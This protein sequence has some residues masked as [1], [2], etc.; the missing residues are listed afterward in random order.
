VS[1][2]QS[3]LDKN[4]SHDKAVE[5]LL[6]DVSS[7]DPRDE[8]TDDNISTSEV[9]SQAVES[10]TS[11]HDPL[12]LATR[13]N[14]MKPTRKK[15]LK[16]KRPN[17]IFAGFLNVHI[18][19]GWCGSTVEDLRRNKHFPLYPDGRRIT[20]DFFERQLDVNYGQRI[21]G[22][23]HPP[24]TGN[25]TFYLSSDDNSELWLSNSSDPTQIRKI[26]WVGNR[27]NHLRTSVADFTVSET[28]K[29]RNI[30][31]VKGQMYF[32]E[33]L[34]KQRAF[35]NHVLVA[36]KGPGVPSIKL[37][38]STYLSAYFDEDELSS[39]VNVL[40]EYIPE[41]RASYPTHHHGT[42]DV[43]NSELK[44]GGHDERDHFHLTPLVDD[45]DIDGLLPKCLYKPSYLVDFEVN[46]YEGVGLIHETAVYPDDNTELTHMI[47]LTSCETRITDSHGNFLNPD[48]LSLDDLFLN[49]NSF[50]VTKYNEIDE[51]VAKN[52]SN[53]SVPLP[54]GRGFGS[55]IAK[56][57]RKF[58]DFNSYIQSNARIFGGKQKSLVD[59]HSKNANMVFSR[60]KLTGINSEFGTKTF[61]PFQPKNR[62]K[63]ETAKEK[64]KAIKH[65]DVRKRLRSA[66]KRQRYKNA[67]RNLVEQKGERRVRRTIVDDQNKV[68]TE[69]LSEDSNNGVV[70]SRNK[71]QVLERKRDFIE[72]GQ[73]EYDFKE[74][75]FARK[76]RKL[77]ANYGGKHRSGIVNSRFSKNYKKRK[78]ISASRTEL[79]GNRA[80]KAD[81]HINGNILGRKLLSTEE[82][83]VVFAY[84]TDD[85][86]LPS[87]WNRP[88]RARPIFV[89]ID[90]V[91]NKNK[92]WKK[93]ISVNIKEKLRM[94]TAKP[95]TGDNDGD[96][97]S[98]K[99]KMKSVYKKLN[100][101]S[102]RDVLNHFRM[103]KY[104]FYDMT[105]EEP[106][107]LNWIYH[108]D[109]TECK[110]NGNLLLNE[111][112]AQSVVSKYMRELKRRH[113]DKYSLKKIV[114][115]EEN[116]DVIKGDRYLIE[117]DLKVKGQGER[118]VRL[119][120]YVYQKVGAT[121]LCEPVGFQWNPHT[122]VHVIVPVKNQG[123]WVQHF[124]DNM[125]QIYL[126]TLDSH[127]NVIIVDF[128]S[129]DIDIEKSLRSSK[130]KRYKLIKLN[131]PFQR[132]L[133]IQAG[134]DSVENPHDIIFTCDLHLEIPSALIDSI[135]KHCVEGKMAFAPVVVRLD[136][137]YLPDNPY[138]LWELQ[139]Y[140]LFAICKSDFDK[141]GGM[142]T[143]EFKT[144]WGGEDWEMLDRILSNNLEVERLR[145][146]KFYHYYHSKIGMWSKT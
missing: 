37:I 100:I 2:I 61:P 91:E 48:N 89:P 136:C 28:Q 120:K 141:A 135:R 87:S 70:S 96:D 99:F 98:D 137:G 12:S 47:P 11:T 74:R 25:F 10:A 95:E 115:V 54:S 132:A 65:S 52:S 32:V 27:T 75:G 114:N 125:E 5:E 129:T 102:N 90:G 42:V 144:K 18:W 49:G 41:T 43:A 77:K 1:W 20:T 145:V 8:S 126:E 35:S 121:N 107:F 34:H 21:F 123:R 7:D 14:V 39:D 50:D 60:Q 33:A 9:Y 16:R 29:S 112:V 86:G 67:E 82:K 71:D 83:Q 139:G 26:A 68:R 106:R 93:F 81:N 119:S 3:V 53:S 4:L 36:W 22:F 84:E 94:K 143:K 76:E 24:K 30:H 88:K 73:E 108:R 79:S 57:K 142:N 15:Q 64:K 146:P 45:V 97:S 69:Y 13:P 127:V 59:M 124:I 6:K 23:I 133:G 118:S 46:R 19:R 62:K 17:V 55:L 38:D 140:G 113:G 117:L 130:L 63:Q 122:T 103:F 116:H 72:R 131:G 56:L 31:L 104:A 51:D 111:K 85:E 58:S 92:P 40:A 138:G 105:Q 78:F 80:L 44:F 101:T 134:A 66:K 109:H 128:N 110:S